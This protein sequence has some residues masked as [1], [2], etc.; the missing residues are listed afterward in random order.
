MTIEI[1]AIEKIRKINMVDE[2]I[3]CLTAHV[4]RENGKGSE[5][6]GL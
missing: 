6:D 1:V 3:G 4:L 2:F 5:H